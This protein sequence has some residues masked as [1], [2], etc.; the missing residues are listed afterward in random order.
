MFTDWYTTFTIVGIQ[1]FFEA[2]RPIHS[3]T[4]NIISTNKKTGRRILNFFNLYTALLE[5]GTLVQKLQGRRTIRNI[6]TKGVRHR[7]LK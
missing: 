2:K 4:I 6:I 7:G 1:A 3:K 5:N